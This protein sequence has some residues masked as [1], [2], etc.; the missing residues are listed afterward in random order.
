MYKGV[1]NPESK[2]SPRQGSKHAE[3]LSMPL[4]KRVLLFAAELG[5][6]LVGIVVAFALAIHF[7]SAESQFPVIALFGTLLVS[8][9]FFVLFRRKSQKWKIAIDAAN[10]LKERS[11]RRSHP[12]RA[13]LTRLL[14]RTLIRLPSLI[15]ALTVLFLPAMSHMIFS[16]RH[17]VP[18]Y[19]VSV[20]WNWTIVK[21]RGTLPFVWV[22]FSNEGAARCGFTPL[23]FNQSLP[24]GATFAI[25]DPASY[26]E[27]YRP[28]TE[29]ADGRGTHVAQAHF[30]I[31]ELEL[32]CWQYVV[33]PH[34]GGFDGAHV[35]QEALCSTK[36]N[37]QNF[38]LHA[39]FLGRKEDIP[40]FYQVLR[41]AAPD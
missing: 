41:T 31:G 38:N 5:I 14:R 15:A 30:K 17:L 3:Q 29:I 40:I 12:R 36:P 18:Q 1:Y 25:S 2:K 4:L 37:G 34:F 16:G 35:L 28:R 21:S 26:Y 32:D 24:S 6:L 10:F 9:V 8:V 27:W 13:S 22:F 39:S 20:P 19:R 7:D 33:H 11:F 23:W